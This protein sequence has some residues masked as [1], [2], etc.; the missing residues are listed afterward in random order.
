M[1]GILTATLLIAASCQAGADDAISVRLRHPD[2]QLKE[3][4][5]LF[6][7]ARARHPAALLASWRR[8]TRNP[9]VL[10]KVTQAVIASFNPEMVKEWSL[11]HEAKISWNAPDSW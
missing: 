1:P 7:N 10:D 2:R 11:L 8:A 4:L 5:A 9:D 6:Q 3:V